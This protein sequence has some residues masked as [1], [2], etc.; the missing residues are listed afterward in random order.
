MSAFRWWLFHRL[1][2]FGWWVCPEPYKKRL[3]S[4]LP[5]WK[6]IEDKEPKT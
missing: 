2:E 1:S 3:Q 4:V 5:T 6:D